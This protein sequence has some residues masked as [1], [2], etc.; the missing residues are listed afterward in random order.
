MRSGG[1]LCESS[2]DSTTADTVCVASTA[3]SYPASTL[4]CEV[5]LLDAGVLSPSRRRVGSDSDSRPV[6]PVKPYK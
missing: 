4:L 3:V 5:R 2:G 1:P 6:V